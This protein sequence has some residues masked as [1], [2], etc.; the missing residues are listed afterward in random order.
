MCPTD[1]SREALGWWIP[2]TDA[3]ERTCRIS[4][5]VIG[6]RIAVVLPPGDA[7]IFEADEVDEVAALLDKA[8]TAIEDDGGEG[9]R[10]RTTR[11]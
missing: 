1:D 4:V 6:D 3:S 8:R 2:G 9:W 11:T 7:L 5:L 10:P